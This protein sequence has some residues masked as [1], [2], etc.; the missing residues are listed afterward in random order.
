[1]YRHTARF[2][3][4]LFLIVPL[5]L[6]P[7][8]SAGNLL[9]AQSKSTVVILAGYKLNPS[10]PTPATGSL[11]L[12]VRDDTLTVK[13]TFSDLK[14]PYMT[15]GIYFVQERRA[16]NQLFR[17]DADLNETQT[18]GKLVARKNR[19]PLSEAHRELLNNGELSIRISSTQHKLGEIGA[20]IPGEW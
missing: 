17:I 11:T 13:G 2:C 16:V 4:A 20:K 5:L 1:M 15:G 3:L 10:V 18:G 14:A 6:C 9:R 12:T 19:F 7:A 8:F